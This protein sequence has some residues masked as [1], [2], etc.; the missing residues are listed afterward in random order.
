MKKLSLTYRLFVMVMI[1]LLTT[2]LLAAC[3]PGDNKATP[4]NPAG[5][6]WGVWHGWTAPVSLIIG[7]F[8]P[9]IRVYEKFNTGWWYDFGYYM[10]IISG[11][12]SLGLARRSW[13]GKD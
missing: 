3:V 9:S 2:V 12:G 13:S 11:F 1:L 5:F 6:F 4:E 7:I 8:N 10:A